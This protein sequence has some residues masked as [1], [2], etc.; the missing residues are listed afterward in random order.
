M[1]EQ[2]FD[3]PLRVQE[4][5]DGPGGPLLERFAAELSHVGYAEITARRHIRAAGHLIY[6]S[7]CQGILISCLNNKFVERNVS[8]TLR[9]PF[10]EFSVAE[11]L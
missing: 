3:D 7:G 5:R 2:F 4:L 11:F 6:W 9:H 1:F 8:T 10:G